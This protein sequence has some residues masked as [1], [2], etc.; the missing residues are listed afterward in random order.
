MVNKYLLL[1]ILQNMQTIVSFA[2]LL[3]ISE[4]LFL[5]K[6]GEQKKL[7]SLVYLLTNKVNSLGRHKIEQAQNI[8][9]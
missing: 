7:T 5:P 2:K 8:K 6:K 4:L 3:K 1:V 9:T